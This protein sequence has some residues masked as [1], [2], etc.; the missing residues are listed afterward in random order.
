MQMSLAASCLLETASTPAQKLPH[1]NANKGGAKRTVHQHV[2]RL[3]AKPTAVTR[4]N[5]L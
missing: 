5:A 3:E 2:L 4:T 1:R